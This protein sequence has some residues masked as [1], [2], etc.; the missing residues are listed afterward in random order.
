MDAATA[1]EQAA[2]QRAAILLQLERVK[3]WRV[4]VFAGG[5]RLAT[6]W[7]L[8][9]YR[10]RII[11]FFRYAFPSSNIG[12]N[13]LFIALL[14]LGLATIQTYRRGRDARSV[15]RR[16]HHPRDNRRL[17][18]EVAAPRSIERGARRA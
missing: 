15:C 10:W 6:G 17:R 8:A 9:L 5:L 14:A 3:K 16:V 11:S 2:D 1:A 13:A 4:P 18:H 12:V 7:V